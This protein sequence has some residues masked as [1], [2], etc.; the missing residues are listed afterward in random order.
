MATFIANV[1]DQTRPGLL[2]SS[3]R[4]HFD[5]DRDNVHERNINR[6]AEAGVVRGVGGRAFGPDRPVTRGQMATFLVNAIGGSLNERFDYFDDDAS[7]VHEVNINK[8]A[9]IGLAAGTGSRLFS[10]GA[11]T[12]RDQMASFVARALDWSVEAGRVATPR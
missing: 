9:G 12:R 6:L 10:P 8:V 5:D 1:I 4:D 7:N 11:D 3:P 2:P